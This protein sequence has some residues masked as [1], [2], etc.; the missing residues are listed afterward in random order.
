MSCYHP[1][2]GIDTGDKTA[3]GKKK[4]KI[5]SLEKND[6]YKDIK[7]SGCVLIPCGHCI[8][9]RLDYSRSWADRMMLELET[10]KKGLFVTL[11]YSNENAQEQYNGLR[12]IKFDAQKWRSGTGAYYFGD[13]S[14]SWSQKGTWSDYNIG[15]QAIS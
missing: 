3:S 12:V 4:L 5:V 13:C 11:T 10:E 15:S 8:G 7:E 9:C 2:I 6:R 14:A 1:L